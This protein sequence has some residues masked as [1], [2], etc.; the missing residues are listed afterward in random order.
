MTSIIKNGKEYIFNKVPLF[1]NDYVLLD[2]SIKEI[3]EYDGLHIIQ[4]LDETLLNSAR[5]LNCLRLIDVID[6]KQKLSNNTP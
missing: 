1:L 2:N 5:A 4:L 6:L 3:P